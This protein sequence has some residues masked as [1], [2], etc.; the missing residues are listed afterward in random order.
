MKV[1]YGSFALNLFIE[2]V[3]K[4]ILDCEASINVFG[5]CFA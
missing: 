5:L 4:M 3:L 2:M 1:E